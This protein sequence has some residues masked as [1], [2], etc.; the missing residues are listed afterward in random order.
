MDNLETETY[1]GFE[2]DPVKYR[3]YEEVCVVCASYVACLI[4]VK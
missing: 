1:E 2:R 3:Q 4:C